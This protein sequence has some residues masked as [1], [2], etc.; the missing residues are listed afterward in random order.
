M[1]EWSW[2]QC[3]VK[4]ERNV[5]KRW[6]KIEYC[7]WNQSLDD[8]IEIDMNAQRIEMSLKWMFKWENWNE[9]SNEIEINIQMRLKWMFKWDQ[10][11][12]LNEIDMI[13]LTVEITRM[14]QIT[15]VQKDRNVKIAHVRLKW[16]FDWE[17]NGC[18]NDIEMGVKMS[19][20]W[21]VLK[22]MFKWGKNK[23]HCSLFS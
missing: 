7:T 8:C 18:P 17:W 9:C 12:C 11:E 15:T 10:H 2:A 21:V 14:K 4:N 16:M 20:K 13:E 23:F 19:W 6:R 22:R 3:S 5:Q 1:F